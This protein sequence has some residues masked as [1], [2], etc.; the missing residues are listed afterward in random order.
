[1]RKLILIASCIA[2]AVSSYAQQK[3]GINTSNP[4]AHLHIA[5]QNSNFLIGDSLSGPGS[6]L[7]WIG[8]KSAFRAGGLSS[9]TN[10]NSWN[11]DSIGYYSFAFGHNTKAID[12][13]GIAMGFNTRVKGDGNIGLGTSVSVKGSLGNVALG[14]SINLDGAFGTTAIGHTASIIGD[15]GLA[16]IG[17]SNSSEGSYGIISMGSNNSSNGLYGVLAIGHNNNNT[18][19]TGA[20]AIGNSNACSGTQGSIALGYQ[21][22]ANGSLGAMAIGKS[23]TVSGGSAIAIGINN[24][25]NGFGG[26]VALGNGCYNN[27]S[28]GSMAL[29]NL[30]TVTGSDGVVA[31]GSNC[32]VYSNF[33]AAAIGNYNVVKADMASCIGSNLTAHSF[34][35]IVVG[36][37]NDT[38]D[39]ATI[40][41]S[42]GYIP[43]NRMFSVGNGYELGGIQYRQNAL[44]ILKNGRIGIGENRPKNLLQLK[45]TSTLIDNMQLMV[46]E[47][48]A[49]YGR[50]GFSNTGTLGWTQAAHRDIT[51]SL[52]AMNFY[53]NQLNADVLSLRGD[54]SACFYGN[55]KANVVSTCSDKRYKSNIKLIPSALDKVAFIDGV[56]YRYNVKEFP[57]L[58]F[59]DREQAGLIA[60]QVEEVLPQVVYTD[61]KGYK[62]VDY[63]KVVPLLVEAIKELKKGLEEEKN[64]NNKY[65]IKI[66]ARLALL[67]NKAF[68]NFKLKD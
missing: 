22:T 19:H 62:S 49:G 51:P 53:S 15:H 60:Q 28:N 7:M 26:T 61:D 47:N 5:N 32:K 36:S 64:N 37:Y 35:E 30:C 58:H 54:G 10:S 68:A 27:G 17:F 9:G 59:P 52:S 43:S 4:K 56:T 63:A 11:N 3:V 2:W 8:T 12:Y 39:Y 50:I 65:L 41:N 23:N 31:M 33:G 48:S 29:G 6:K 45:T 66:E 13:Y 20:I 46:D 40:P 16:S 38:L 25:N 57:D 21:N 24:N 1:M 44:V 42:L 34:G 67:E 55:V 14:Q 18:G